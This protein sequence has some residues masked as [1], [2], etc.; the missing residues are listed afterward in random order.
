MYFCAR[1]KYSDITEHERQV[2]YSIT[3]F[4]VTMFIDQ[5]RKIVFELSFEILEKVMVMLRTNLISSMSALMNK[6]TPTNI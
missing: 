2:K 4:S 6:H 1:D 5:Y 3:F